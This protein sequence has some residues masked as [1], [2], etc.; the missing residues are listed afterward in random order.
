MF[1]FVLFCALRRHF[2]LSRIFLSVF[3]SYFV[4]PPFLPFLICS[5]SRRSAAAAFNKSMA[6]TTFPNRFP[7][8]EQRGS[9][10]L[11]TL[12]RASFY[13]SAMTRGM[14]NGGTRRFLPENKHK[15]NPLAWQPFG[16]GP[17]N[18]I[19]MRFAQMELRFTLANILRRFR[20]EA[21]ENTDKVRSANDPTHGNARDPSL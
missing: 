15:F 2:I 4:S 8:A 17:R 10:R 12:W 21:T 9:F 14:R 3:Y 16:A 7:T 19:G 20:L 1:F 18:C 5:S 11:P 6:A 13:F